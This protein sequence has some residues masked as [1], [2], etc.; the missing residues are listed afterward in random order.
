IARLPA[1]AVQRRVP[2]ISK[3]ISRMTQNSVRRAHAYSRRAPTRHSRNLTIR[4]S[5]PKRLSPPTPPRES[6]ECTMRPAPAQSATC[7]TRPRSAKNSRSPASKL[8]PSD[9]ITISSPWPNCWSL[10]RGSL[11]PRAPQT[12]CTSPE[13]SIPH[14]VRPPHKYGAPAYHFCASSGSA[15]WRAS[16]RSSCSRRTFPAATAPRWPSASSTTPRRSATRAPVGSLRRPSVVRMSALS[17]RAVA[18]SVQSSAQ[19]VGPV[20]TYPALSQAIYASGARTRSQSSRPSSTSSTSPWSTSL[21]RGAA[22]RGSPSSGASAA[23]TTAAGATTP[24]GSNCTCSLSPVSPARRRNASRASRLV[25][26]P[27]SKGA[28]CCAPTFCPI[29]MSKTARRPSGAH[30]RRMSSTARSILSTSH[31]A[32]HRLGYQ[33]GGNRLDLQRG[34]RLHRGGADREDDVAVEQRSVRGD[35]ARQRIAARL[36]ER[37]Q[38][39]AVEIGV[40]RDHGE[41]RIAIQPRGVAERRPAFGEVA[42]TVDATGNDLPARVS[43]IPDRIDDNQYADNDITELRGPGSDPRRHHLLE[44]RRFAAGSTATHADTPVGVVGAGI[45]TRA[46]GIVGARPTQGLPSI[47][48]IEDDGR[49]HDGNRPL[50]PNLQPP[51]PFTQPAHHTVRGA[52]TQRRATGEENR[53]DALD[54]VARIHDVELARAGRAAA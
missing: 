52:Q 1:P 40:R 20:A 7:E 17:E 37:L 53:I 46:V 8:A 5:G 42:K 3:R 27:T 26:T 11:I 4:G 30:L 43:H 47:A 10:S 19:S 22:S 33:E 23:V 31:R 51:T 24:S 25:V 16:T 39:H 12:A 15:R 32:L 34:L 45:V 2:S 28:A 21:T 41:R 14:S 9:A 13:Q 50:I 44:A 18:R 6:A 49:W 36:R 54:E 38:L 29:E 48:E 35:A